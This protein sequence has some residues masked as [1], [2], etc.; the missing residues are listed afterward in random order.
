M[1]RRSRR[2]L[3]GVWILALA[4][5][6]GDS[7]E[8]TPPA[9]IDNTGVEV[10]RALDESDD[11]AVFELTLEARTAEAQFDASPKTP[12]WS[13]N[14]TVPGPL[15][16]A[17]VGD[18]LVVHF[19]NSLDEETTIHW[20]GVRVP[21][22]M[23]GTLAMQD[24]VLPGDGFE[25]EFT[26]KDAGLYWFHPHI[27]GDL[28]VQRGLYGTILVRGDNEPAFDRE[29]VVV[30]DDIR[31]KA[32]GEIEEY[33]DDEGLAIGREGNTL[34]FNGQVSPTVHAQPGE[35]LRLRLVNTANGRFFNLKLAGHSFLVVGT[36]GGLIPKPFTT[37]TLLMS[38]GERY[39]VLVSLEG[40]VGDELAFTTEPYERGHGTGENPAMPIATL[41]LD[42]EPVEGAPLPTAGPSTD[43]LPEDAPVESIVLDEGTI[44]GALQFTING[45][46]Y[47]DVAPIVVPLGESRV[48]ELRNDAE[49]DHPFHLHG[50]FFQVI[51]RNGQIVPEADRFD[52]DTIIVPMESSMKVVARFDEPGMWMY[53]CHIL[54]HAELGMMGEVHVE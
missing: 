13:Y 26:L 27:R 37:K 33:P 8:T 35:T 23:D 52:K 2:L 54:E 17:N 19:Q 48:L 47:P 20:H 39:D 1:K 46:T 51:E 32:N 34:L 3:T 15:I 30:L 28:Q 4:P 42:G 41:K 9:T 14:G 40:N 44:D 5:A 12:V 18:K 10:A 29:L 24:P 38:P 22:E 16:E 50:F 25:Y 43:L 31:L 6:C 21:A 45:A 36:D 53:H 49:M 11:P 7:E